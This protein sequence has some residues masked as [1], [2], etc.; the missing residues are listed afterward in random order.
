[1]SWTKNND[2][3]GKQT[4][5]EEAEVKVNGSK[6]GDKEASQTRQEGTSDSLLGRI[7]HDV[8]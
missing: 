8:T 5:K 1:M 2:K 3:D 6:R 7:K 4:R